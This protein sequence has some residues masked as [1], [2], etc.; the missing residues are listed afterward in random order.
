MEGH[1]SAKPQYKVE[2]VNWTHVPTMKMF[3]FPTP[4]PVGMEI[5][6]M[7]LENTQNQSYPVIPT[8]VREEFSMTDATY[9]SEDYTVNV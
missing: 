3:P 8:A 2:T 6:L 9:R 1:F 5:S 7:K 4:V